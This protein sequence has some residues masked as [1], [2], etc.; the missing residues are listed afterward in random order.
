MSVG[1]DKLPINGAL[2]QQVSNAINLLIDGKMNAYGAFTLAASTTTT[3]VT[4]LR[5]GPDS[6]ILFT[7]MTA[8]AAGAVST[9][10]I[11]TRAKQ[12]FTLTHAN[13]SQS[14]RTYTYI[15]IA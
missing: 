8:N 6:I 14:D 10:F 2:P 5:S 11:S 12:S 1:Y 4:D 15:V 13:N 9:T 3:V 7:P